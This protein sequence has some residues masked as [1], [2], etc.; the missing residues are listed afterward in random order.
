MN[1]KRALE[2]ID[3]GEIFSLKVVKFNKTKNTGGERRFYSQLVSTKPKHERVGNVPKE[4]GTQNHYDNST[5]NLYKC[6]DGEPTSAFVKIHMVHILE[7]NGERV[8]L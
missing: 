1:L 8:M 5:R 7:V 6:I 3:S 4:N 2:I